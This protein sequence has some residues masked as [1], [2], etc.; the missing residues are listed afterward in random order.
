MNVR[1]VHPAS[2]GSAI[3][4]W[5]PWH[6]MRKACVRIFPP[7]QTIAECAEPLVPWAGNACPARAFVP[8]EPRYAAI[9]ASRF[10]PITTTAEVVATIVSPVQPVSAALAPAMQVSSRVPAVASIY[11]KT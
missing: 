9:R 4:L 7:M 10:P 2:M 5:A 6:A 1:P 3:V 8:K 11:P